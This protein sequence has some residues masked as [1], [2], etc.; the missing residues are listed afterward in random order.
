MDSPFMTDSICIRIATNA[1]GGAWF[2][3]FAYVYLSSARK[4]KASA[5]SGAVA[6]IDITGI[7]ALVLTRAN[8]YASLCGYC[9]DI[10]GWNLGGCISATVKPY[11]TAGVI[12]NCCR[13]SWPG[14]V[15]EGCNDS[16][17]DDNNN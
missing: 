14:D 5:W 6:V 9:F 3:P 8:G 13:R 11:C 4:N 16:K 1:I 12:N 2:K 17:S 7:T 10:T 15:N